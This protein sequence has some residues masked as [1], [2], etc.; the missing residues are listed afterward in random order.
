M[1][2]SESLVCSEKLENTVILLELPDGLPPIYGTWA[3]T[4]DGWDGKWTEVDKNPQFLS[5]AMSRVDL[6]TL[7][8]SDTNVEAKLIVS[9]RW[10]TQQSRLLSGKEYIRKKINTEVQ[11]IPAR[12]IPEKLVAKSKETSDLVAE[13]GI[14]TDRRRFD[15][16]NHL[17]EKSGKKM[18]QEQQ[19]FST[20]DHSVMIDFFHLA[21]KH[22]LK[23]V[24]YHMPQSPH[25]E[26]AFGTV[27]REQ[28]RI[29]FA[30]MSESRNASI[31]ELN[32]SS[33]PGDF[34]D[35]LHLSKSR[36]SAFTEELANQLNI[37][38]QEENQDTP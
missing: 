37:W 29:A 5:A 15:Q 24:F 36:R 32:W 9:V 30:Q 34:P 28:D 27:V 13:G 2:L 33:E 4:P 7:W 25:F 8:Q 10:V 14:V 11:E 16:L 26:A 6:Q 38:W 12:I 3:N 35:G 22:G 18:V 17:M 23:V 1:P 21:E 20:W 19:P 31:L